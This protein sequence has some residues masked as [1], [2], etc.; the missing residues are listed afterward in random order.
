[1]LPVERADEVNSR[2]REFARAGLGTA[3]PR[4]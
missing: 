3:L 1:M 2:V 4:R